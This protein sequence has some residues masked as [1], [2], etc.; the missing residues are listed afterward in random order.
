[1]MS[2][3]THSSVQ[4]RKRTEE[5]HTHTHRAQQQIAATAAAKQWMIDVYN[6]TTIVVAVVAAV[7]LKV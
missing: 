7:Y 5:K 1:M 4:E 2:W 3:H 6:A